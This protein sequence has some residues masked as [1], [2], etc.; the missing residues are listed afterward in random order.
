MVLFY[1]SFIVSI[2]RGIGQLGDNDWY[3]FVEFGTTNP[4]EIFLQKNGF[5]REAAT[6]MKKNASSFVTQAGGKYLVSRSLL[7]CGN[8]DIKNE[9]EMVLYNRPDLFV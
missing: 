7:T 8:S 6:F 3:E 1:H 2:K 9:C 4:L 5:S